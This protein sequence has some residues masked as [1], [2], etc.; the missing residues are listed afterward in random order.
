[1]SELLDEVDE[2]H[3]SLEHR[4]VLIEPLSPL[5]PFAH[6]GYDGV[7]FGV[8]SSPVSDV[9]IGTQLVS[10]PEYGLIGQ[11]IWAAVVDLPSFV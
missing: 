5:E 4:V 7:L 6:L 1:M 10:R 3:R 9:G 8:C 11:E 2:A